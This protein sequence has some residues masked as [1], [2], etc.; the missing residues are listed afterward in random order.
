MSFSSASTL[1]WPVKSL[2]KPSNIS[3]KTRVEV[4][5][6]AETLACAKVLAALDFGNL[7]STGVKIGT[8][9]V[10]NLFI[11]LAPATLPTPKPKGNA[12]LVSPVCSLCTNPG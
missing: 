9:F 3:A 7:A 12:K 2:T 4:P 11:I 5:T 1:S 6:P 8:C 10:F